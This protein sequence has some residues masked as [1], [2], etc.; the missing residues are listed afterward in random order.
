M[1][2]SALEASLRLLRRCGPREAMR[3][4]TLFRLLPRGVSS[5]A[6][7]CHP[8]P[9]QVAGTSDTEEDEPSARPPTSRIYQRRGAVIS[10]VPPNSSDCGDDDGGGSLIR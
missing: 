4:E 3:R 8:T 5:D 1:P 7:L 10:Q 9:H 2:L 6:V